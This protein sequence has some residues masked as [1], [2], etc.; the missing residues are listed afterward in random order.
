MYTSTFSENTVANGHGGAIYMTDRCSNADTTE[1]RIDDCTFDHNEATGYGGA[2]FFYY[3]CVAEITKTTFSSNTAGVAGGAVGNY[4]A[5]MYG[6]ESRNIFNDNTAPEGEDYY[7]EEFPYFGQVA[8]KYN[9]FTPYLD[10]LEH[11]YNTQDEPEERDIIIY[12][13]GNIT[14]GG[15]GLSW[16]QAVK[17]ITEGI[18]I[19]IQNGNGNCEI[20]VRG[21]KGIKYIPTT[22]PEWYNKS[23][24]WYDPEKSKLIDVKQDIWIFGG[25]NGNENSRNERDFIKY[26]T[27]ISAQVGSE[28]IQVTY[29]V[30]HMG[31]NSRI[32]GFIISD[33]KGYQG[34]RMG[35]NG[36]DNYNGGTG[37]FDE[38]MIDKMPNEIVDIYMKQDRKPELDITKIWPKNK[39]I[40]E[41][42]DFANNVRSSSSSNNQLYTQTPY[43]GNGIFANASGITIVN[44]LLINNYGYLGGGL[45]VLNHQVYGNNIGFVNNVGEYRGGAIQIDV[46]GTFD[47]RNCFFEDNISGRKGGAVYLD[48]VS[49]MY[50]RGDSCWFNDNYA[51]DGGGGLAIDGSSQVYVLS[52][53]ILFNDNWAFQDGGACYEGSYGWENTNGNNLDVNENVQVTFS[54]NTVFDGMGN[55]RYFVW[56]FD[57]ISVQ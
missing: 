35:D 17:T 42:L 36:E 52:N 29:Q 57:S 53:E 14:Q 19:A 10:V 9:D 2:A 7:D 41:R 23:Q 26:P 6:T 27:Q 13:N 24:V 25:F 11:N 55:E 51:Y 33:A 38:N 39:E 46:Q 32:D 3:D 5:F 30:L 4:N 28:E 34:Q 45:Y 49:K 1:A 22:V 43:R 40:N 16:V 20:W 44:C 56:N 31:Q 54:G 18:N 37:I 8:D 48:Y 50:L 21:G 12:V 47:C 15:N